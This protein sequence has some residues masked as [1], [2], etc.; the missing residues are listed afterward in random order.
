M[1]FLDRVVTR[2]VQEIQPNKYAISD[3]RNVSILR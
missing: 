1:D 3:T 2:K